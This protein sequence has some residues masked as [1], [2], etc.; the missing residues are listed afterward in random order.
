[1]SRRH[2]HTAAVQ[3]G[4][5]G[6][7]T[8]GSV[9]PPLY[10]SANY[11]FAGFDQKR[12]YDYTRSGNPTR[13]E[14]AQA[15]AELEGGAGAVVTSTGMSAITLL[16]HQL[17]PQDLL[18]VPHDGYGGTWRLVDALARKG[19]FEVL[20]V[21]Q[22]DERAL[23]AALARRPRIVWAESPSNP[24]L[25]LV[26]LRALA[27]KCREVGAWFVVDN[28]FCSPVGQS[29]L[30]L[31]ADF[32]VHS[33]TKYV[34]GH[35]DVVGGAVVARAAALHEQLVWWANALGITGA[36]FDS[37][38]SL[39]GLRTLAVRMRQHEQNA[40]AI[41]VW[42]QQRPEVLAVHYPGLASHPDHELAKRQQHGFGGMLAFELA[43]EAEV[44]ALFAGLGC[45]T[46]AESLGGVE[47]LVAH[48]AT[49]THAAM[50]AE[51][52]R[53]AGIGDGLVRLSV[54]IE[55]VDDLIGDLDRA[56][57]RVAAAGQTAA[58][59]VGRDG[60]YADGNA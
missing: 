4:I 35:S 38:L 9:A 11:S 32:V 43:G 25:R 34:N 56:F 27:A 2:P 33:T 60:R 16:L 51:A 36:P 58:V 14:F 52:R 31:G 15:L 6:D 40:Q 10:L 3:C 7:P 24:L 28:T 21:D 17:E 54:G 39:R 1:M 12:P 18:V 57:D 37:W 13:D 29:P 41:A 48:P 42:L 5:N 23:A 59:G 26:D 44:R 46:L 45:F 20:F 50:S 8:H 22:R 53:T 49:M 55:H 19:H 30:Q 47:S